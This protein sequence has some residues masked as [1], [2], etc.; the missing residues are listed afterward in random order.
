MPGEGGY[1]YGGVR[2]GQ[3]VDRTDQVLANKTP[4][5]GFTRTGADK[6]HKKQA[7]QEVLNPCHE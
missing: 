4:Y 7:G 1:P 2:T 5:R 3:M 6:G